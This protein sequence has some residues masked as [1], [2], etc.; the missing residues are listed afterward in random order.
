MQE[1]NLTALGKSG[2]STRLQQTYLNADFSA[3]THIMHCLLSMLPLC[4]AMLQMSDF[5][6]RS[7]FMGPFH[8][9]MLQAYSGMA[10]LLALSCHN[11]HCMLSTDVAKESLLVW[12]SATHSCHQP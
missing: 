7:S 12:Q 10:H 4:N 1:Q 2:L 11:A 8:F 9:D 5:A 6:C 3:H